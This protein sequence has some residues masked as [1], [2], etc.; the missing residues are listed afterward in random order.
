M[1]IVLLGPHGAGKTTLGRAL[2]RELGLR[3]D[4]EVGR[5]LAAV[6]ALRAADATAATPQAAFDRLVFA[7]ELARDKAAGRLSRV[8]ETWHP[9][10][11]AYAAA[12]S[13]AVARAALPLVAASGALGFAR[14]VV[15]HA[16]RAVL[17]ARQSEPGELAFFLAVAAASAV[18]AR[19]L[20]LPI[21]ARV[22]TDRE[23]PD[24]LA[25]ELARCL[26]TLD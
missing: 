4:D 11:L 8:V 2:A 25:T 9:G 1:L 15:V 14:V 17:R 26:V 16:P 7:V 13:P 18:F 3:L 10:N 23:S 19:A 6:P 12:R 5:R 20:G 22:R 24:R 21:V